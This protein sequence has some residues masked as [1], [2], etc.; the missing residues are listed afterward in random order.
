MDLESVNG[1]FIDKD[2]LEPARYYEIRNNDL[3]NFGM[4]TR[5]Y[6]LMKSDFDESSK[7]R[8]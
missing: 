6:V 7:F 1:T 4:S 3:I 5:D 2:R 8:Q